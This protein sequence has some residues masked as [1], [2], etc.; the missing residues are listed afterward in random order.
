MKVRIFSVPNQMERFTIPQDTGS[1]TLVHKDEGCSL[2]YSYYKEPTCFK[3]GV[4]V[5]AASIFTGQFMFRIT[6]LGRH[7]A[8]VVYDPGNGQPTEKIVIEGTALRLGLR[9]DSNRSNEINE[10]DDGGRNWVW[11]KG[12]KGAIIL[13]NNDR[14]LN[15]FEPNGKHHSELADMLMLDPEIKELPADYSIRL[16]C[17]RDAAT[18]FSVYRIS[19]NGPEVVLGRQRVPAPA[20]EN[21]K[22]ETS[23]VHPDYYDPPAQPDHEIIVCSPPLEPERQN[24]Y[25][26]A[27]EFP[28]SDFEG[29]ISIELQL[30]HTSAR[31]TRVAASERVVFRVA[32]WIMTPHHLD[33]KHVYVCD[34]TEAVPPNPHFL[35][36]LTAALEQIGIKSTTLSLRENGDDRWIQDEIEFGYSMSPKHNLPV[37]FDSPRDRGLAKYPEEH[38]LKPDFGHFQIG[39]NRPNSLD[40]FGNLE[41][42]PPVTVDGKYYPLGRIVIGGHEY[43]DYDSGAREMMPQLRRFLHAQR[44][45]SPFEIN[46]DWLFVGHVDEI[47]CFV[48]ADNKVGFEML[49]ASVD[50]AR[51]IL[52]QLSSDGYG[53]ACLFKNRQRR[54]GSP[55]ERTISDLLADAKFWKLNEDCQRHMDKNRRI[56]HDNLGIDDEFTVD[57]PVLFQSFHG[58]AAYFPD[59]INHLVIGNHSIAPKPYGPVVD[60]VDQFEKAFCE[61]LP[62]RNVVFI[63]DW[64]SYH[65]RLGEVHC[66]TNCLREPPNVN[67]WEHKPKGAFDV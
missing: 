18:R 21:A 30:Q 19:N 32:P 38:L 60:G 50:R 48:P 29:L 14:D 6:E 20:D 66:G 56:L 62:T 46:T 3:K 22:P 37:V 9:V 44:V 36:Q 31:G 23:E 45:Q 4:A 55:A 25:V 12:Q 7:N 34:M 59:M 2:L 47:V 54:D 11:G 40:S 42:S 24:F 49:L 51:S 65:E 67:W 39:G 61:A 52:Q 64:D 43:G 27:H 57:I 35:N 16:T 58:A 17:S 28:G 63:E 13:A 53:N 15:D 10:E 5:P 8:E 1:F 41:V 26:E 33:A